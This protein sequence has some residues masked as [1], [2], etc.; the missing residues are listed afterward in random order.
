MIFTRIDRN[1]YGDSH[2]KNNNK[3]KSGEKKCKPYFLYS[4]GSLEQEK[5]GLQ[6]SIWNIPITYL[7]YIITHTKGWIQVV[8]GTL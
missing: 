8:D 3:K 7:C 4:T 1:V 2:V 5:H 6:E